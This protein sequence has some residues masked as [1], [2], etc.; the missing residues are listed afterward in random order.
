MKYDIPNEIWIYIFKFL[1][2]KDIFNFKFLCKRSN[3]IYFFSMEINFLN[4]IAKNLFDT[5]SYYDN[6]NRFFQIEV[7]KKLKKKINFCDYLYLS[8]SVEEITNE[9]TISNILFHL[10]HCPRSIFCKN[11]CLKCGLL[12]IKEDLPKTFKFVEDFNFYSWFDMKKFDDEIDDIIS[13]FEFN[14]FYSNRHQKEVILSDRKR[15]L[16]SF[17]VQHQLQFFLLFLEAHF[18]I[19][20]NFFYQLSSVISKKEEKNVFLNTSFRYI[21]KFTTFSMYNIKDDYF[22]KIFD[23]IEFSQ[24]NFLKVINNKYIEEVRRRENVS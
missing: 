16:T 11:E 12:F 21:R 19:L 8:F 18:R 6:F 5:N 4:R 14:I 9:M 22:Q 13:H 7:K 10:F 1:V 3:E 24:F 20:C 2:L 23:E 17:V 15:C